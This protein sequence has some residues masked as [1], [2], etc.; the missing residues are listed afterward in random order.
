MNETIAYKLVRQRKDGS[1]GTLFINTKK[2]L[3]IGKWMKAESHPTK[4]FAIRPG[5]HCTTNPAA[6]HLSKRGRVWVEVTIR[7]YV[8]YSRPKSQG[9]VW[10]LARKIKINRILEK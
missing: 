6:P 2:R 5:W 8:E 4:G 1:L 10:L 7:D 9:G 3:E